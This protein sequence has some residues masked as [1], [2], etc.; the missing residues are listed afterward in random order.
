M[1]L[2][3]G[4]SA[5]EL[6]QIFPTRLGLN[7]QHYQPFG[8]AHDP[9]LTANTDAAFDGTIIVAV[10]PTL[11]YRA[12]LVFGDRQLMDMAVSNW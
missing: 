9:V 6:A 5:G 2:S 11:G 10:K 12:R 3:A 4:L 1:D 7:K 8:G